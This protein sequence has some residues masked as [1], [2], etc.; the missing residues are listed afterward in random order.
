MW[1]RPIRAIGKETVIIC[2]EDRDRLPFDIQHRAVLRYRFGS[3]SDFE[4]LRKDTTERLQAAL[5]KS[6]QLTQIEGLV[7]MTSEGSGEGLRP[8]EVAALAVVAAQ[9]LGPASVATGSD[10]GEAME[11][12]GFNG[13]ATS[14]A[15]R[16]LQAQGYV[17]IGEYTESDW[18]NSYTYDGYTLTDAGVMWLREH[19]GLL[20]LNTTPKR[21]PTVAEP[22]FEDDIPF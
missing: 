9:T 15:L 7:S 13:T 12:Q 8:Y 17:A 22:V 10:V 3:P 16:S 2:S 11:K 1:S 19:E 14:L 6:E 5:K 18:N 21:A 20:E 4:R